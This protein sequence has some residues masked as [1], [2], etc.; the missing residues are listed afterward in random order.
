MGWKWASE[1]GMWFV[2]CQGW[3]R[4]GCLKSKGMLW[5]QVWMGVA[6][7]KGGGLRE[8]VHVWVSVCVYVCV[9]V[10]THVFCILISASVQLVTAF[11]IHFSFLLQTKSCISKCKIC[12]MLRLFPNGSV[13]LE[14]IHFQNKCYCRSDCATGRE[15]PCAGAFER[16]IGGQ[17]LRLHGKGCRVGL[18]FENSRALNCDP[19]ISFCCS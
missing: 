4:Q 15:G 18:S 19:C 6:P 9:C 14:Q 17:W 3:W 2:S 7:D 1:G 12:V 5:S 10:C 11:C 13:T 8:L 16:S